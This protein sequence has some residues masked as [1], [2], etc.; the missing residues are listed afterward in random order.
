MFAINESKP[1]WTNEIWDFDDGYFGNI[2]FWSD[3]IIEFFDKKI[4]RK[5][6]EDLFKDIKPILCD[7]FEPDMMEL[8]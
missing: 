2:F 1:F 6:I 5:Q 8:F 7:I 4:N 3:D